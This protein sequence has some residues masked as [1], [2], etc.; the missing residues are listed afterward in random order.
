MRLARRS[1]NEG[2]L[3]PWQPPRSP[4][5]DFSPAHEGASAAHE[6]ASTSSIRTGLHP[7]G[8]SDGQGGAPA[9]ATPTK[10]ANTAIAGSMYLIKT[11]SPFLSSTFFGQSDI[12][13]RT[14]GSGL[15]CDLQGSPHSPCTS[16]L[17]GLSNRPNENRC[18]PSRSPHVTFAG[19]PAATGALA[20]SLVDHHHSTVGIAAVTQGRFR[21]RA[22]AAALVSA[23][24][25]KMPN[26]AEPG[27]N[28]SNALGR[29]VGATGWNRPV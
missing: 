12:S 23:V 27:L 21:R 6:G 20:N 14:I 5:H 17:D 1:A 25:A 13:V 19:K 2:R 26:A 18:Y 11:K 4:A 7:V 10:Q 22:A 29:G 9:R 16:V 15:F 28:L 8:Q 24:A 3:R